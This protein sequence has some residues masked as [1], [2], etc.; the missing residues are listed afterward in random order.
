MIKIAK[1]KLLEASKNLQIK[2]SLT[3]KSRDP[4][5]VKLTS[6]PQNILP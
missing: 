1:I 6:D 4:G 2:A 5:P 3:P